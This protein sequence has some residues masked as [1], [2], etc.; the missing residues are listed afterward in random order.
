MVIAED[1]ADSALANLMALAEGHIF[2]SS[3]C[4]TIL[5]FIDVKT[6]LS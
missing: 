1:S 2:F 4:K 6:L 3:R 5:L